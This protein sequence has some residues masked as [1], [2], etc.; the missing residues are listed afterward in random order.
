M[1]SNVRICL[2]IL[3]C[4]NTCRH[5]ERVPGGGHYSLSLAEL[6]SRY[7][8]NAR[9]GAAR[10]PRA[11][12]ERTGPA[13]PP[14]AIMRIAGHLAAVL[15]MAPSPHLGSRGREIGVKDKVER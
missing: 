14:G 8:S 4:P 9:V 1:K 10:A 6:I 15:I 13:A 7:R 3:R 11:G 12:L 5:C 2:D